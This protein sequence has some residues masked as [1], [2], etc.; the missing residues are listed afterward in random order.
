ML[1]FDPNSGLSSYGGIDKKGLNKQWLD[2][3]NGILVWKPVWKDLRYFVNPLA[4]FFEED[5]PN[6]GYRFDSYMLNSEPMLTIIALAAGMQNGITSPERKWFKVNFGNEFIDSIDAVRQW[7]GGVE[8]TMYNI[9]NQSNF[10]DASHAYYQ[11][12]GTFC[13]ACM[14]MID[15][16]DDLVRFRTLDCG[17]YAVGVGPNHQVNRLAR[18]LRLTASQIVDMFGEEN[19]PPQILQQ[20]KRDNYNLWWR[21][22]HLIAP[23]PDYDP[24]SKSNKN[25]KYKS[26]YWMDQCKEGQY[27]EE[28]GLPA[29]PAFFSTWQRQ[30]F[31]IYG[32]GPGWMIL[33]D[34]KE[35]QVI[36]DDVN[37]A[38]ALANKPPIAVS[39]TAL[40]AGGINIFPGG[41]SPYNPTGGAEVGIK[42]VWEPRFDFDGADKHKQQLIQRIKRSGFADVFLMLDSIEKGNMTA[43]EVMERSQEKMTMLGPVLISVHKNFLRPLIEQLYQKVVSTP[44]LVPP[45]PPEVM[46]MS[47]KIEYVSILAQAQKMEGVTAIEQITQYA[48]QTA[49]ANPNVL[50]NINFDE[51]V[52][53][54]AEALSGPPAMLRSSDEV[55]QLRE[56][57]AKQ[58]EAQQRAQAAQQMADIAQTGTKAAANLGAIDT[59]QN[60][61]L[62]ALLGLPSGQQGAYPA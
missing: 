16:D 52:R 4:G 55:A 28:G 15:D 3:M 6:Y 40:Q 13:S 44:G 27:L 62:S 18:L 14:V 43:R 42:P 19:T 46:G 61:A 51:G 5:I 39:T 48:V 58:M 8:T 2:L 9:L 56:E 31:D 7:V 50:D 47:L 29:F 59:G 37:T 35:L 10:Y 60:N 34:S 22:K 57:R 33:P 54:Y 26:T 36:E 38:R 21:V 24:R 41:V 23:N 32:K 49:Q 1:E 12:L 30:G 11:Q 25:M 53:A 20:T 45:P 17:E